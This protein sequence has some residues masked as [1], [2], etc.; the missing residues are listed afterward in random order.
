MAD[1]SF[2]DCYE[3]LP[4]EIQILA[5]KNYQ[6]LKENP[7]HP[8]LHFKKVEKYW[9]IRV[10]SHYRAIGIEEDE[11]IIWFWIGT[12]AQYDILI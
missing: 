1:S 5:D 3:K 10:R 2:W 12:H 7:K 9:S 4:K 8:S 11:K 6:L